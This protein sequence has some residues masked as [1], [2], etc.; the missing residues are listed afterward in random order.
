MT[1]VHFRVCFQTFLVIAPFIVAV[2]A[3]AQDSCK[4]VLSIG[5]RDTYNISYSDDRQQ[6]LSDLSL[7]E[8]FQNYW[9]SQD[10]S[11]SGDGFGAS[12]NDQSG[13][14][15]HGKNE[16]EIKSYLSDKTFEQ[17]AQSIL[18]PVSRDAIA[19][20]KDCLQGGSSVQ[21]IGVKAKILDYSP[22]DD[23]FTIRISWTP[24]LRSQSAPNVNYPPHMQYVDCSDLNKIKPGLFG[25]VALSQ[26]IDLHCWR[27]SKEHRASFALDTSQGPMRY[28]A[29]IPKFAT[30]LSGSC[31]ASCTHCVIESQHF[32][33]KECKFSL[34]QS[35]EKD[36]D[37]KDLG[38]G[39]FLHFY[40]GN[41]P[42]NASFKVRASG[43]FSADFTTTFHLARFYVG[44]N[45][46]DGHI[47]EWWFETDYVLD[48]SQEQAVAYSN[49]N[50]VMR[51]VQGE[52][53]DYPVKVPAT[54]VIAGKVLVKHCQISPSQLGPCSFH[55]DFVLTVEP[56]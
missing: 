37:H 53:A 8:Q 34:K 27:T 18:S 7:S 33:C 19:A 26:D 21:D 17:V 30:P 29:I 16:R 11:L 13:S 49:P 2:T 24:V 5:L 28:P 55:S 20:W 3:R 35:L 46:G 32:V 51:N 12:N 6:A 15:S 45:I 44:D 22:D 40:C 56:E 10:T 1:R 25:R 23:H 50:G 9:K 43:T 38:D 39:Q 14:S 31:S 54:G 4:D 48:S 47:V 42:P 52:W 36:I 41:L